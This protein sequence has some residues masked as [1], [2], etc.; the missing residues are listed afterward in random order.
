MN[1]FL[2]KVSSNI[3]AD[4]YRITVAKNNY[5]LVR[6]TLTMDSHAVFVIYEFYFVKFPAYRQPTVYVLSTNQSK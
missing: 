4:R 3:F 1:Q 2:K 6:E 5:I